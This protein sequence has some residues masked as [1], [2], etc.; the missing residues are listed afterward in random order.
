MDSL[1]TFQQHTLKP[2]QSKNA[3]GYTTGDIHIRIYTVSEWVWLTTG[4]FLENN[5][6]QLFPLQSGRG[7]WAH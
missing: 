1:P 6:L 3:C 4:Y 5:Y 7:Y 2:Y